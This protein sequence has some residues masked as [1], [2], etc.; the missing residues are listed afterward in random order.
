MTHTHKM[1]KRRRLFAT[2]TF[3][4]GVNMPARCVC[5]DT[6][7]KHDGTAFRDLLPGEYVQMAGRAG[8]RGLDD[9]GTVIILIKG[10]LPALHDLNTMMLGTPTKLDSKFRLTYNMILNLLRVEELRVEDMMKRSFAE[11]SSQKE[12]DGAS[13][14]LAAYTARLEALGPSSG[15]CEV[16]T[17]LAEYYEACTARLALVHQVQPHILAQATKF[18]TAGRVVVLNSPMHRNALAVVLRM[19]TTRRGPGRSAFSA[20]SPE[21]DSASSKMFTVLIVTEKDGGMLPVSR[22]G[23][24]NTDLVLPGTRLFMPRGP[25]G[26]AVKVVSGSDIVTVSK[27]KL[28]L[29][30][31]ETLDRPNP[32]VQATVAQQLVRLV[33]ANPDGVAALDPIAD[34]KIKDM[35]FVDAWH[36]KQ[37]YDKEL[38]S[39]YNCTTCPEFEDH[40]A[41]MHDRK[42]LGDAVAKLS[43]QL[44][45]ESLQ[46]LPE[47][48]RAPPVPIH[49]VFI[50]VVSSLKG[51]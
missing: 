5:F 42:R 44:S 49:F 39:A 18:L 27:E 1:K 22:E 10:D 51:H 26:F 36:Q 35:L 3:A 16:C 37:F 7:R 32:T 11:N 19:E 2:E 9:T 45:D 48:E 17:D 43:F 23:S 40:Y 41:Q 47:Y 21:A 20:G 15:G 28:K 14:Q 30:L 46:M 31:L 24:G 38:T 12:T 33:E 6:I 29:N 25:A 8:R 4:M 50:L 34:M 13:E